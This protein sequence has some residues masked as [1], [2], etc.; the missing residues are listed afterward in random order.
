MAAVRMKPNT[1]TTNWLILMNMLKPMSDNIVYVNTRTVHTN[2]S[3][4]QKENLAAFFHM[5]P[6]QRAD[7]R[8][9]KLCVSV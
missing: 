7:G 1:V 2:G 9:V 6:R 8:Q 5:L 4:V 3:G